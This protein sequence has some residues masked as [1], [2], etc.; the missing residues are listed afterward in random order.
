MSLKDAATRE[1]VLKTLFD[2]VKQEYDAARAETQTLL[3]A[4]A[5]E[6]GTRQVAVKIP[7]GPDIATV[8]LSAGE[9]VAKVIDV[10]LFTKWVVA[11]Y[12]SEVTRRL[13]TEVQPAFVKKLLDEVTAIGTGEWA[14]ANGVLQ[15]VPGVTMAPARARTHSVRFKKDGREH[16]AQAWR[17]GRLPTV[18]PALTPAAIES[19]KD[20]EEAAKLKQRVAELEERDAWLAALER[21]G[22]DNWEGYDEAVQAATAGGAE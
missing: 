9:A 14:D 13:V 4:A 19:G 3:D 7:G 18:L 11:N 16:V 12:G 20:N 21:A 8:S 10:D 2:A 5:E 15:E 1:A 22:V 6:A 17:E